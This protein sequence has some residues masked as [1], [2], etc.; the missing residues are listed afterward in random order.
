VSFGVGAASLSITALIAAIFF[1]FM[2]IASSSLVS[3]NSRRVPA[4]RRN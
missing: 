4:E 2:C 1:Y 3:F